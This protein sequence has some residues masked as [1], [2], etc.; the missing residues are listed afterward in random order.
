MKA[1]SGHRLPGRYKGKRSTFAAIDART[2]NF[3]AARHKELDRELMLAV[4]NDDDAEQRRSIRRN[5]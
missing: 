2:R 3:L 5:G 4:A 1:S